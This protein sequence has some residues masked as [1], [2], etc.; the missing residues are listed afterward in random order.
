M[1]TYVDVYPMRNSVESKVMHAS[2]IEYKT[3]PKA[4]ALKLAL[5]GHKRQQGMPNKKSVLFFCGF[6]FQSCTQQ[7]DTVPAVNFKVMCGC[8]KKVLKRLLIKMTFCLVCI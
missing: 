8:Y 7:S 3:L 5:Y 1:I 4:T 6:A 2:P